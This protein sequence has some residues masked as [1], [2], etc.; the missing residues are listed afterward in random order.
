MPAVPTDSV[1]KISSSQLC[2]FWIPSYPEKKT[3]VIS[4]KNGVAGDM[5]TPEG[6]STLL[7]TFVL[8]G[9]AVRLYLSRGKNTVVS[10]T[11]NN[12]NNI[13]DSVLACL[14]L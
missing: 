13:P 14:V 12:N 8:C 7:H 10:F 9:M 3:C 6:M 1:S 5:S 2:I 11:Q 4:G